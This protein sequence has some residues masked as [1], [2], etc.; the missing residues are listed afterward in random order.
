METR[1]RVAVVEYHSARRV[2]ISWQNLGRV[3]FFLVLRSSCRNCL[4]RKAVLKCLE[5]FVL[6]PAPSHT[7]LK[8]SGGINLLPLLSAVPLLSCSL[9]H[10]AWLLRHISM[11]GSA[12][13]DIQ[14]TYGALLI[15]LLVSTMYDFLLSFPATL[16]SL[17]QPT[18]FM[19]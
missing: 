8:Y 7:V 2:S 13:A 4:S 6:W 15:G 10:A 17:P 14:S 16:L 12:V 5:T 19:V 18:A 3:P 9:P 11:A 1:N